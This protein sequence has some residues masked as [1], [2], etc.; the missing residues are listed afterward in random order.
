V[1]T[2]VRDLASAAGLK[3][4]PVFCDMW[5]MLM[6]GCTI[7]A[8]EGNRDAALQAKRAAKVILDNWAQA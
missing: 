6:K 7:A 2:F 3:D 8:G 1:R 5:H 4:V